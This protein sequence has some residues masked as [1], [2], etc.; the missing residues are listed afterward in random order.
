MSKIIKFY[1][2]APRILCLLAIAFVSLFALDAFQ[3]EL[4]IWKQI[5]AFLMHLIPSF[6]LLAILLVAWKWELVGGVVF[7]VIGLAF[8]PMVYTH[9]F[10]MNNSLWMS[11][12]IIAMITFP[13]VLV[14]ALFLLSY[15]KKKKSV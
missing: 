6:I 9:N 11:L 13:F 5:Q 8:T 3:P 4:S 1:H 14:G 12:L 7:I 15:F 2:W 10:N